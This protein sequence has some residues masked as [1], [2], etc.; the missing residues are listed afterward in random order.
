MVSP[1]KQEKSREKQPESRE[2][3]AERIY[4]VMDDGNKSEAFGRLDANILPA[5]FVTH[6]L[7]G[8][9]VLMTINRAGTRLTPSSS[10]TNFLSIPGARAT[11]GSRVRGG[12]MRGQP[13]PRRRR[14]RRA[15]Q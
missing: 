3:S 6:R 13:D 12:D 2:L 4:L 11:A 5:V 10:I 7:T 14:V 9:V 1:E 8:S 15:M